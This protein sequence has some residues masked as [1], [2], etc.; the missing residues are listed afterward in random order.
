VRTQSINAGI[1]KVFDMP[2]Q[3][4]HLPLFQNITVAQQQS[5]AQDSTYFLPCL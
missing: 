4:Q 5:A 3:Q 1:S 2:A